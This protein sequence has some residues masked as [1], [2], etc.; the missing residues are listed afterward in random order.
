[1]H[2]LL[3][4]GKMEKEPNTAEKGCTSAKSGWKQPSNEATLGNE[5]EPGGELWKEATLRTAPE[6]EVVSM[7][8]QVSHRTKLGSEARSKG[9]HVRTG[10]R[11]SE[12]R[13]V[14]QL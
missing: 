4:R 9:S 11:Q 2:S 6:L 3:G 14:W 10:E 12:E 1:M 7:K 13:T 8:S 5:L